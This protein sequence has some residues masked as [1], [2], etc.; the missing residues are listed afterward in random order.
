MHNKDKLI[1]ILT[2]SAFA[3]ILSACQGEL[4]GHDLSFS[5][6]Q[7]QT[8]D[9]TGQKTEQVNFKH[10]KV[11]D[12]PKIDSAID[13]KY[14]EN[15][16]IYSKSSLIITEKPLINYYDKYIKVIKQQGFNLNTVPDNKLPIQAQ[17]YKEFKDKFTK[18]SNVLLIKSPQGQL[19][20]VFIGQNISFKQPNDENDTSNLITTINNSKLFAYNVSYAVYPSSTIQAMYTNKTATDEKHQKSVNAKQIIS[21]SN[22]GSNKKSKK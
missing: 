18:H 22:D 21:S 14:G 11:K 20:G 7:L 8:Y 19:I 5:R 17:I 13:L 12:D 4:Q 15:K 3:L 6:A 1:K 9:N 2:V 16:I 10:V